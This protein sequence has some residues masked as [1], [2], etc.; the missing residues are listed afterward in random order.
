MQVDPHHHIGAAPGDPR[1]GIGE[2]RACMLLRR[3]RDGIF[4][5]EDDRI[6]PRRRRLGPGSARG[7]RVKDRPR[8]GGAL[9]L[10]FVVLQRLIRFYR[11]WLHIILDH[12]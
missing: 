4:E 8:F 2:Q 6:G 10:C 9:P 12:G 1:D 3:R 5:I 11:F 7:R